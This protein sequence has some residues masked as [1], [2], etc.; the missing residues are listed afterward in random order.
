MS[1][2]DTIIPLVRA[3]ADELDSPALHMVADEIERLRRRDQ[4][5][6]DWL[7]REWKALSKNSQRDGHRAASLTVLEADLDSAEIGGGDE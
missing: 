4:A 6:L 5:V 1:E 2:K 3:C 7:E